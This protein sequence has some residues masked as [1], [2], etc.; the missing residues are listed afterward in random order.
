MRSYRKRY[1]TGEVNKHLAGMP[2]KD[3]LHFGY[4][5]Q[6]CPGRHFAIGEVKMMMI[7]LLDEF[8]FKFPEGKGRPKIF[9]ADE[10]A[11]LNPMSKLMMRRRRVRCEKCGRC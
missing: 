3:Y 10:F 5:R 11:F 4:G 9:H 6:A 1:E 7:R 8:E 2:E